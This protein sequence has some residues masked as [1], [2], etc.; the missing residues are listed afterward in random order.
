MDDE[1]CEF[2]WRREVDLFTGRDELDTTAELRV[3]I[4]PEF[5]SHQEVGNDIGLFRFVRRIH[6]R[7][8]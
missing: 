7:L 1:P 8:S 5:T 6:T 2:F 3:L 4:G